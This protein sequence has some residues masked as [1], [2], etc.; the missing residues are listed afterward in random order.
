MRT[1][2]VSS[3]PPDRCGIAKYTVQYAAA[4]RRE[5]ERVEIVSRKR[6]AAQHQAEMHSWRGL[7]KV[8]FLTYRYDKTVVQFFPDLLFRSTYT[9]QFLPH[10]PWLALLLFAGHRVDLIV[11]EAPYDVLATW[12][13]WRGRLMRTLWRWLFSV[14]RHTFVHTAWERDRMVSATGIAPGKVEVLA[15]GSSFIMRTELDREAARAELGLEPDRFH[16]LSIGFI[17]P[18]K[19]F[20]R[21]VAA[22]SRLKGDRARVHVVGSVRVNVERADRYLLNLRELVERT[23]GADLHVEFVSDEE[24]DRWIVACD[25]V[26]LP[27]RRIVSS[28]VV[29]R[30]KLYGRPAIVSDVGGMRDQVADR[31]LVV[32]DDEQ[33]VH[34]MARLAGVDV[35]EEPS[36]QESDARSRL[37]QGADRLRLSFDDEDDEVDQG[38]Q[39]WEPTPP[40]GLPPL[41]DRSFLR[42]LAKTM[43]RKLTWW[44]LQPLVRAGVDLRQAVIDQQKEL[45]ALRDGR[46]PPRPARSESADPAEPSPYK[47]AAMQEEL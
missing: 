18:H 1:L 24:F 26:V 3:Y 20:D 42:R 22:L 32:S 15:H 38:R 8:L 40:V 5:G 6:S 28:G 9:R 33:L 14:P 29:E 39:G 30:A 11:H 19:G 27:Y 35:I 23:P 13:T 12:P 47:S 31:E 41:R 43:V 34:A 2:I 10:W 17:Q 7:L 25:A 4:K 36:E 21:P 16:F 37:E 44:E 46:R 45:D